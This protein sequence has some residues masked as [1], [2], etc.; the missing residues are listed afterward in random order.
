MAER[1]QGGHIVNTA[2]AAAYQPSK[3]LPAYSTSKA[4][5]LMLSEC[6][7]AE[8]AGQGIG[9]TRDLPRLRQHQHHLDRAL[10]RRR[11]RRGEA[12]PEE[13]R[14]PVRPA[15]LPA[16]EGRRR[17]PAR[18]RPQPGRGPG[19][20]GG[21]RR[22]PDVP[23]RPAGAAGDRPS[24]ATAVS[25]RTGPRRTTFVQVF[26]EGLPLVRDPELPTEVKGFMGEEATH[27]VRHAHAPDHGRLG[28]AARRAGQR[29]IRRECPRPGGGRPAAP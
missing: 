7:R 1:G 18:G 27:S 10:R 21:P 8:L 4:A 2:S 20:P 13:V 12:A 11:R 6:L 16:G 9:V 14:A 22:P 17:D 5:V 23:L 19:H 26:E 29:S 15:E 24:G 25:A 28:P 3:A